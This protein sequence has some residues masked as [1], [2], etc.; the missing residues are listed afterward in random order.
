M[1]MGMRRVSLAGGLR[2]RG[3]DP[4]TRNQHDDDGGDTRGMPTAAGG[5][6]FDEV[7]GSR[8]PSDG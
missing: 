7:Y 5:N 1:I 2:G 4:G 3:E 6:D 8:Q